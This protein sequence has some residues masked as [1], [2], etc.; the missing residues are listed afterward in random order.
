MS[1]SDLYTEDTLFDGDLICYQYRAGYRFSVDAVLAAHFCDINGVATALDLASGSGIIGLILA[2]L[3]PELR[4]Q[5]LEIQAELVA[6][7][8][9]NIRRNR[10]EGRLEIIQGDVKQVNTVWQAECFDLVVCNPP[11]RKCGSGRI[12]NGHQAAIARHELKADL[13]DMLSAAK[14]CVRN[15]GHVVMV[16][17]ATRFAYLSARLAE[18]NLAMRRLQ[19]VYSYPEAEQAILVLVDAVKNGGEDCRIL[20]SFTVYSEKN[21]PYSPQMEQMYNAT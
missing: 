17:P 10:M 3:H 1:A 2:Y 15:H 11:Y 6:L 9:K 20:P 5:G 14:Y 8:R 16:Y 4:L 18:Q 13:N 7:A 21:G 12:S 19:P